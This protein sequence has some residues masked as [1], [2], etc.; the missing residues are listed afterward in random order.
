MY[1]ITAREIG[2]P[3]SDFG[4]LLYSDKSDLQSVQVTNASLTLEANSAGS[5]QIT[6]PTTNQCYSYINHITTELIVWRNDTNSIMEEIWRGRV[7]TEDTDFYNNRVLVCEGELAYLNDT[8]Q[9]PNVYGNQ[10]VKQFLTSILTEHNKYVESGK[11]FYV[12]EV[13][14]TDSNKPYR[15]TSYETTITCIREK[16]VENYG[17]YIMVRHASDGKRYLDYLVDPTNS[18]R[19]EIRFG[20]NI[21]DISKHF[22]LS[23]FATAVI[24]LGT[25]PEET[26]YNYIFRYNSEAYKDPDFKK[27]MITDE[28]ANGFVNRTPVVVSDNEIAIPLIYSESDDKGTVTIATKGNSN[29]AVLSKATSKENYYPELEEYLT[30]QEVNDGRIDLVSQ[31]AVAMY[32]YICQVVNFDEIIDPETLKSAGQLYLTDIQFDNMEVDVSAFD[33]HYSDSK[34]PSIKLFDKVHAISKPHKMDKIFV[35]TRVEVPFNSPDNATV[36][37]N[38]SITGKSSKIS[39]IMAGNVKATKSILGPK[40][41]KP[42]SNS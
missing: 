25:L 38:G 1:S 26:T 6:I 35:V 24:P 12:G 28:I 40:A 23:S 19:Q 7:L 30:I 21:L 14:V 5:L 15:T 18:S 27:A 4:K 17:G 39:S 9:P 37:L 34:I 41:N 8:I 16:L 11:K 3:Q 36:T 33:I 10:T 31:T 20:E 22:D 13:T 29:H 2:A 42:K 32:G